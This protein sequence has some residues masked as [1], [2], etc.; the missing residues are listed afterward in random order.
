MYAQVITFD[1][2]PAAVQHGIEHV[3]ADVVPALEEADGGTG[4]W[5]VDRE[6]G[7]RLS[8]LVWESEEAA[9]AAFARIAERVAANPGERPKPAS[10]ERFEIYARV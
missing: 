6:G 9:Q 5:L 2:D 8:I 10:V 1:E 7:K 3:L 4:L